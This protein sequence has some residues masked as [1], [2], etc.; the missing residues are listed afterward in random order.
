M[1]ELF[2]KVLLIVLAACYFFSAGAGDLEINQ[3]KKASKAEY[4]RT[5]STLVNQYYIE[6][7]IQQGMG[8]FQ[9]PPPNCDD[10]NRN[11][12]RIS[13]I[14]AVCAKL[15]SFGCDDASEVNKVA[16]VC[17]G[18]GDGACINTVCGKLGSFGCDDIGE[19]QK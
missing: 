10:D 16:E 5:V 13:C 2:M 18:V 19:V 4:I 17:R 1:K 7:N 9:R 8:A 3:S 6:Q 15:G 11:P 12:D 14:D